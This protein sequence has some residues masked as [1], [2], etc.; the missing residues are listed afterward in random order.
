MRLLV[1]GGSAFEPNIV[2]ET[3]ETVARANE[4]VLASLI[5]TDVREGAGQLANDWAQMR[6]VHVVES[7]D[8]L[9]P[10]PD[11]AILFPGTNHRAFRT[12]MMADVPIYRV[13]PEGRYTRYKK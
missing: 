6:G 10:R 12:L 4:W 13:S 11:A 3:I 2:A 5:L 8:L 9:T 1:T 7:Q